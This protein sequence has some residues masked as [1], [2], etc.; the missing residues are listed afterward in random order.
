MHVPHP[1]NRLGV[2]SDGDPFD[3]RFRQVFEDR[4]PALFRYLDRLTGDAELASDVAQQAFIKL[5]ELGAMPE[6]PRA[7]LVS[8]AN[9]LFRDELRRSGRRLRLLKR[10]SPDA[11]LGDPPL[12]PDSDLLP[13]E[14]RQAVRS[15]LE[16]LP[17]R[18]RQ[19]LLLRHEGYSYRELA[20]ALDLVEASVGT[21]LARATAAF[22]SAFEERG[23]ASSK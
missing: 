12:P 9:N 1:R 14:R 16:S 5:Y 19:L 6:N 23:D 7:W 15:A 10:R 8:V 2:V 20:G 11:T 17:E 4:F 18:D 21:L 3:S 22:R 13:A